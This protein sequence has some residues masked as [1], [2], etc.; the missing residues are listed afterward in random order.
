[1]FK[2]PCSNSLGPMFELF[3]ETLNPKPWTLDPEP[4]TLNPYSNL[5]QISKAPTYIIMS[6]K[7]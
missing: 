3:P 4:G 7:T 5:T 2:E 1:M 6:S